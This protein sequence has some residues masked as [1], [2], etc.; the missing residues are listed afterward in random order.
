MLIIRYKYITLIKIKKKYGKNLYI[1]FTKFDSLY[2]ST[3]TWRRD[4]LD[5]HNL[6]NYISCNISKELGIK[7]PNYKE[8]K[9]FP[10]T[11]KNTISLKDYFFNFIIF[12]FRKYFFI[13]K[14]TIIIDGYFG[15]KNLFLIFLRSLG[16]IIFFPAKLFFYNKKY[17]FKINYNLRKKIKVKEEDNFDTIFNKLVSELIPT[18]LVESYN[19]IKEENEI[20]SRRI[21]KIGSGI[22]VLQNENFKIM[23]AQ[24]LLKKNSKLL[25]F[26]HGGAASVN[27]KYSFVRDEIEDKYSSK[28]Y[29]WSNKKGL[30]QH[31][32]SKLN[33]IDYSQLEQNERILIV[34]NIERFYMDPGGLDKSRHLNLNCNYEFFNNL[35]SHCQEKTLVKF[36]PWRSSNL[37]KKSWRNRFKNKIKFLDI[38]S[39]NNEYYKSKI[40]IIDT[41]STAFYEALYIG[42]PFILIYDGTLTGFQRDFRSKLNILKKLNILHFSAKS[43]ATFIN[44]NYKNLMDWWVIIENNK[45]FKDIKKSLVQN[46]P[47]YISRISEE[48]K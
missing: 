43:A 28:N 16:K 30:G 25:V 40:L 19:S 39:S 17:N 10:K 24:V 26:Q 3:Q 32:F 45:N 23:A 1:N 21:N 5:N 35:N 42:I 44:K 12:F 11:Y 46:K 15:K 13:F 29:Y 6:H 36:F 41:I 34:K 8:K 37:S 18:T 47:N 31:Y 4:A 27:Q 2:F 14:P 22:G 9:F 38:Y 33:K 7:V 48:L 20:L